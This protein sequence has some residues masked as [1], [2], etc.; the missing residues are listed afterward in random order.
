M[1]DHSGQQRELVF[2]HACSN[3]W[4]RDQHGLQ[5]PDCHSDVVEI[6]RLPDFSLPTLST[7][8]SKA[9][10]IIHKTRQMLILSVDRLTS[11]TTHGTVILIQ[12][13]TV[14]KIRPPQVTMMIKAPML[15]IIMIPGK[16]K[17]QILTS[18]RSSM[19]N[20]ILHRV[21]TSL[22]LPT[23]H[24]LPWAENRS[25]IPLR[26]SFKAFPIYLKELQTQTPLLDRKRGTSG[27]YNIQVAFTARALHLR[28]LFLTTSTTTSITIIARGF[29]A[30]VRRPVDGPSQQLARQGLKTVPMHLRPIE[31]SAISTRQ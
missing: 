1:A 10:I 21:S 20:G 12:A 18:Q 31:V 22:A 16:R 11:A 26:P 9:T 23:D 29:P 14:M 7:S 24:L 4:L 25:M 8:V 30:L 17:P 5:C 27:A 28:I 3:E 6:V 15:Y 2:C 13:M 19:L